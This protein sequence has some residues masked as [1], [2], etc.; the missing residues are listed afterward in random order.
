MPFSQAAALEFCLWT[1]EWFVAVVF[2]TLNARETIRLGKNLIDV[3]GV[4]CPVGRNVEGSAGGELLGNEADKVGLHDAPF[5]VPFFRP[6][7]REI[8]IYTRQ[9]AGWHLV[10]HDLHRVVCNDLQVVNIGFFGF[11]EAMP[12]AGFVYF[13]AEKVAI[14][15]GRCLIGRCADAGQHQGQP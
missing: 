15:I 3:L 8:E 13:D 11:Q 2:M 5:V 4:I 12:N 6:R 9:G 14:G 1:I 7:I 10:R